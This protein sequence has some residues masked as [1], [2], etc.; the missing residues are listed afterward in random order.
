MIFQFC[1]RTIS[2]VTPHFWSTAFSECK[3][4]AR[5][6]GTLYIVCSKNYHHEYKDQESQLSAQIFAAKQRKLST[7]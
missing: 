5:K 6:Y 1:N 4:V 7:H 2:L 3:I